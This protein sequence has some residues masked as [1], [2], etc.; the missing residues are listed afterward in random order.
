MGGALAQASDGRPTSHAPVAPA[1]DEP[2]QI[3]TDELGVQVRQLDQKKLI[4][5]HEVSEDHLAL[6]Q[7]LHPHRPRRQQ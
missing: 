7:R 3:A 1:D 4:L 5:T 6:M 2:W